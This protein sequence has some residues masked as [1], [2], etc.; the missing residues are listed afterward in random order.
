M[1][2]LC[3][4]CEMSLLIEDC[5]GHCE[6]YQW[7]HWTVGSISYITRKPLAYSHSGK[8][9]CCSDWD[10]LSS[11]NEYVSLKCIASSKKNILLFNISIL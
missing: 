10:V 4:S 9:S 3:A 2:Y 6:Y 7:T 1:S 11:E 8:S 5:L